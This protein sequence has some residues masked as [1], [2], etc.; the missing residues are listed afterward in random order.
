MR[1]EPCHR[2]WGE[3]SHWRGEVWLYPDGR[4]SRPGID[5]GNYVLAESECIVLNWDRWPT[6][7][8]RW[9]ANSKSYRCPNRKF[10][11]RSQELTS[12]VRQLPE[13]V[14]SAN[15]FNHLNASTLNPVNKL[16]YGSSLRY[17]SCSRT[18]EWVGPCKVVMS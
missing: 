14:S 2:L 5:G 11:L 15:L 9:D 10:T 17:R 12:V 7:E 4:F 13:S 8:L 1:G 3:H 16:L 18:A 6:E